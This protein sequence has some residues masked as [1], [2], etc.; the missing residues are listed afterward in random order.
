DVAQR[1]PARLLAVPVL[2]HR[3][4]GE[5]PVIW[6][7]VT[8]VWLAPSIT[9]TPPLMVTAL[10][11]TLLRTRLSWRLTLLTPST[12][13]PMPPAV[14]GP[15]EQTAR[16]AGGALPHPPQWAGGARVF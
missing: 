4:S 6:F 13:I 5:F 3:M 11:G 8:V 15:P 10:T 7:L 16:L 9:T 2:S 12:P 1:F 14:G